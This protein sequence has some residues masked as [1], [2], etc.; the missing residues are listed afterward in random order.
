M[1]KR[2]RS[3][4]NFFDRPLSA[5]AAPTFSTPSPS[6]P[7]PPAPPPP[8]DDVR[9][10]SR[11]DTAPARK[12]AAAPAA[13]SPRGSVL[14]A[15]LRFKGDLV[16]D[17]DLVVQGQIEGSILHTRSLTIGTDGAM[18][19]DIRARR[20][21]IEGTVTGDLYALE[22]VTVR[23]TGHVNGSIYAPRVAIAEGAQFNGKV[24][25]AHAPSVPSPVLAGGAPGE[26]GADVTTGAGST[27][28]AL[29]DVAVDDLLGGG[30][31]RS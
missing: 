10:E 13:T 30:T 14:G 28:A 24:D 18:K 25:M 1:W 7:T 22:C 31:E 16:A 21:V 5:D 27:A 6:L 19:G 12:A 17:E 23:S 9:A 11:V 29:D 2:D 4:R 15:T 20:I 26:S 8:A 3:E